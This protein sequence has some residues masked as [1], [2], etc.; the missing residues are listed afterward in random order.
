MKD[1]PVAEV[2]VRQKPG[3]TAVGQWVR[4]MI[5]SLR[6]PSIGL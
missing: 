6:Y 5:D 1:E 4:L 3:G 2:A